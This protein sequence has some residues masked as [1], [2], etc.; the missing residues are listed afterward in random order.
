V[1]AAGYAGQVKERNGRVGSTRQ[2]ARIPLAGRGGSGATGGVRAGNQQRKGRADRSAWP[3]SSS[4]VAASQAGVRAVNR[5]E[6][7]A[8]DV[9]GGRSRAKEARRGSSGPGFRARAVGRAGSG[10]GWGHKRPL[11]PGSKED[12]QSWTERPA[13][14][15]AGG[16]W[17]GEGGFRGGPKRPPLG[18]RGRARLGGGGQDSDGQGL[19]MRAAF[20]SK[21]GGSGLS[22]W[23]GT[24]GRAR[25]AG[26]SRVAIDRGAGSGHGERQRA[27]KTRS[28]GFGRTERA[29]SPRTSGFGRTERSGTQAGSLVGAG[30]GGGRWGSV[31][32]HGASEVVWS[33][34]AQREGGRARFAEQEGGARQGRPPAFDRRSAAFGQFT[35]AAKPAHAAP[36]SARPAHAAPVSARPARPAPSGGVEGSAE[37]PPRVGRQAGPVGRQTEP[38]WRQEANSR[39][40]RRPVAMPRNTTGAPSTGKRPRP[41]PPIDRRATDPIG[42]LDELA[43]PRARAKLDEATQVYSRDRYSEALKLLRPLASQ[44]PSSLAVRELLGLTLY[45]LGKWPE[46]VRELEEH[47][48]RSGSYNQYPVIADC[49][50]GL[51]QYR[52]AEEV[53][54]E[55]RAAS[56]SAEVMAE[57]R[58]VAAGIRADQGDLHG[59]IRLLEGSVGRSARS[60]AGHRARQLRQWYALADLY[61]RA[62]E[63]PRARD[64]FRRVFVED[65][66]AYD[67]R[68]RLNA[69]R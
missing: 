64:L 19:R 29:A 18:T 2:G 66:E 36:V 26:A 8:R 25:W 5:A 33:Q 48:R 27:P 52:E 17:P 23:E 14:R 60:G 11:G 32:R 40:P 46:A 45:R 42:S 20:R 4:R 12:K 63:L 15:R 34:R 13:Q 9:D 21:A 41:R 44:Y 62:G 30:P 35:G 6:G 38:A 65:P 53:W 31:A 51:R 57:G 37:K 49:Y 58:M 1:A 50:R 43:E 47:H 10:E 28:A 16:R 7:I 69:L 68:H 22:S 56:P 61:E 55:L 67:V 39:G 24:S 59:A 54:D 3:G